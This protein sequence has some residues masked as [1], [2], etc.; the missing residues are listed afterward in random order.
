MKLKTRCQLEYYSTQETPLILLLQLFRGL[1]YVIIEETLTIEPAILI[2]RYVDTYGNS[3]LRLITPI[4]KLVISTS[5]IVQAEEYIAVDI[6]AKFTLIQ[7]LP[8]EAIVYLLPSRFCES[9]KLNSLAFSIIQNIFNSGYQMVAAICQWV[10]RNI[11]YEHNTS[12][13]ITSA[14]DTLSSQHGVC[15]DL[16]HLAIALCRSINIPARFVVGYLYLLRP[17]DLHAWFEVYLD[18]KWYTFDAT[19]LTLTGGRVV[20]AYGRDA[21]DVA[22]ATYFGNIQLQNMEVSVEKIA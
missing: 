22:I 14:L 12:T 8:D 11:K 5:A 19:Q 7:D 17:M 9:D 3:C 2:R 10:N 6:D 4:G 18:G 15:R 16:S 1:P 13:S 20:L 21:A